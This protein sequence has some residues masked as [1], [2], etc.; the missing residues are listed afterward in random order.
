MLKGSYTKYYKFQ[1]IVTVEDL[2]RIDKYLHTRCDK[3]VY[4]FETSDGAN[5]EAEDIKDVINYPNPSNAKI[6]RISMIAQKNEKYVSYNYIIVKFFNKG[7]WDSSSS[8]YIANANSNEIAAISKDLGIIIEQTKADYSWMYS[9]WFLLLLNILLST[10]VMISLYTYL[11]PVIKDNNVSWW[12]QTFILQTFILVTL[13]FGFIKAI[14]WAYPESVF[15]IGAQEL[16][17]KKLLDRRNK[18]LGAISTIALGGV[19]TLLVNWLF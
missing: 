9:R 17:Y 19:S 1:S 2:H 13:Y 16:Y 15:N 3:V 7:R 12:V 8:L 18:V 5:Y 10:I 6:E 4:N 11:V 14:E